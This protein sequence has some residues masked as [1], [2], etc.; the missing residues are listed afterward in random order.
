MLSVRAETINVSDYMQLPEDLPVPVD[1]GAADHLPGTRMPTVTVQ[2]AEGSEVDLG[3]LGPGLTVVYV[4]PMTGTPGVALPEGWDDI[5]GARGC[6]PETCGF[7]DHF[8]QLRAEGADRVYGLS[9]QDLATQREV[10]DRLRLP[11]PLLADPE[12][13]LGAALGLPTFE[14]GGVTRYSR[15]TLILVDD[16]IEHVFYPVFPPNAHAIEVLG[17]LSPRE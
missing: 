16:E 8:A 13:K 14:A 11:Y 3:A 7:R 6:T 2:S 9:T 12:M 17:W 5:P 10:V 1:D 15:L 4:Y